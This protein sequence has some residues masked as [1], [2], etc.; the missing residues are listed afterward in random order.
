[1]NCCKEKQ[2][3]KWDIIFWSKVEMLHLLKLVGRGGFANP[4]I[5][6]PRNKDLYKELGGECRSRSKSEMQSCSSP[7]LRI[8]TDWLQGKHTNKDL[9]HPVLCSFFKNVY[10]TLVATQHLS[11]LWPLSP[12]REPLS[13][14]R[15]K[16]MMS[17]ETKRGD[18]GKW[19]SFS[20]ISRM[21][22]FLTVCFL[23]FFACLGQK[24]Y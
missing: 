16:R 7:R 4:L 13:S 3:L 10:A 14:T 12:Q 22:S 2:S 11:H 5:W 9:E 18:V 23:W 15:R 1:M 20:F 19:Y 21:H 8:S 24:L 6:N 17:P